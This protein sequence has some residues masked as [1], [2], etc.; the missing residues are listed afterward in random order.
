MSVYSILMGVGDTGTASASVPYTA[1]ATGTAIVRDI[2]LY[3]EED[4]SAFGLVAV[5]TPGGVT[6]SIY[7][8]VLTGGQVTHQ[9][10]GRQVLEPGDQV[11]VLTTAGVV[12]Y[13][14]SGYLLGA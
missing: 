13:R 12:H 2:V 11:V 5:T 7:C 1:P 8:V 4:T 14:I 9:W 10:Q 3:I 6:T